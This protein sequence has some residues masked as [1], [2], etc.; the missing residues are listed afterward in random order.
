MSGATFPR[1]ALGL[2]IMLISASTQAQETDLRDWCA[3]T[4]PQTAVCVVGAA[5][6]LPVVT[7]IVVGEIFERA[8]DA[9]GGVYVAPEPAP[10]DDWQW[11]CEAKG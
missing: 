1:F 6:V 2:M 11:R 7:L 10:S 9:R 4:T 3:A 5:V 8:C